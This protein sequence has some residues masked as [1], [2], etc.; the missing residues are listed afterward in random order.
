MYE[1]QFNP[2]AANLAV[3]KN[4]FKN[5]KVLALGILYIISAIVSAGSTV[6]SALKKGD[7][8]QDVTSLLGQIDP[9]LA[10]N[11]QS[12]I[13]VSVAESSSVVSIAFSVIVSAVLT[14]L[15]AVAFISIYSKSKNEDPQVTPLGGVNILYVLSVIAMVFTIIGFVLGILCL[16]GLFLLILFYGGD[17]SGTAEFSGYVIDLDTLSQILMPTFIVFAVFMLIIL[18][19]A[20]VAVVNRKNYYGSVKESLTSVELQNKGAKGFGVICVISAIF[21]AF[22]LIGSVGSILGAV[23]SGLSSTTLIALGANFVTTLLSFLILIFEAS[24]ALGYKR[25][26]DDQKYGYRSNRPYT[27]VQND[28]AAPVDNGDNPYADAPRQTYGDSYSGSARSDLYSDYTAPRQ[29]EARPMVC[30]S[31]GA[32]LEEGSAFCGNCGT[33]L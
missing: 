19:F 11:A 14:I 23:G 30:P 16:V 31:C 5:G 15:I 20:L 13:D 2:Y 18:I 24:V 6:L 29:T 4:Y 7:I 33:R 3:V 25:Y 9:D 32:P 12:Y 28:F 10:N 17:L 1:Q 26:I 22:S 8:M 21:T 27:A